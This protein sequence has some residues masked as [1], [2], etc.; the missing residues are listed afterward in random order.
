MFEDRRRRRHLLNGG[1]FPVHRSKVSSETTNSSAS[2]CHFPACVG[3]R[4]A[5]TVAEIASESFKAAF[6]PRRRQHVLQFAQIVVQL[7]DSLIFAD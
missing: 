5:V 3:L 2:H 6:A 4:S 7:T 1:I